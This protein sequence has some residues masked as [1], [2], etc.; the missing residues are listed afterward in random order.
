MLTGMVNIAVFA[1]FWP[2]VRGIL[3][4][5]AEFKPCGA[6]WQRDVARSGR[7]KWQEVAREM[8]KTAR[9][10]K[11]DGKNGKDMG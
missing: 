5:D 3:L 4:A 1:A 8:A 11:G 2:C 9:S 10:G 6:N 7:Q